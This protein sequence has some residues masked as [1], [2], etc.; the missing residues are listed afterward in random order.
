MESDR[1][2]IGL[3]KKEKKTHLNLIL[4]RSLQ[5]FV[6]INSL[7]FFTADSIPQYG[8]IDLFNHS[9]EEHLN[10]FQI[11]AIINKVAM[12]IRVKVFT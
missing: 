11:F 5:V 1:F 8:C 10:C 12:D 2:E 6:S 7:F 9:P 3:M 4:L